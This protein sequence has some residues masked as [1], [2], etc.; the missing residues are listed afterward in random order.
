MVKI[1]KIFVILKDWDN[2]LSVRSDTEI[3]DDD[4]DEYE[5]DEEE[6]TKV[7]LFVILIN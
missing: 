5:N 7:P 6:D 3:I 2:T 4:E 1:I